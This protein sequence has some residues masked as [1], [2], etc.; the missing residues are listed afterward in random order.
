YPDYT[1]NETIDMSKVSH[2]DVYL[3]EEFSKN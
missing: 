2:F 3:N 1:D